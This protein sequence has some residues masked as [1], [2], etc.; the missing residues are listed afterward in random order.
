MDCIPVLEAVEP[1]K[2]PLTSRETIPYS[3][4]IKPAVITVMTKPTRVH[5]FTA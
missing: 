2:M 4:I 1:R 5:R 3:P